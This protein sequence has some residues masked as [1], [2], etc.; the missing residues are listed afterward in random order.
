MAINQ[1]FEYL[2]GKLHYNISRLAEFHHRE[3]CT[4]ESPTWRELSQYLKVGRFAS[5]S[6]WRRAACLG[7]MLRHLLLRQAG[8]A[9][10]TIEAAKS[11][12]AA[13]D[14][15]FAPTVAYPTRDCERRVA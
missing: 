14:H 13:V 7:E 1:L 4:I 10:T 12:R 2:E 9:R 5:L 3:F 6:L 8:S 15:L 11:P